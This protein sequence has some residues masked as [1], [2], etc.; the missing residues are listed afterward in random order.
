M[1]EPA[2]KHAVEGGA[3]FIHGN[4]KVTLELLKEAGLEKKELEG[5]MWQ[6]VN[7]R[8]KKENDFFEHAGMV[9]EK[10][11]ELK[12]DMS[13]AAFLSKY[14]TG[15]KYEALGNSLKSYIEGYYSG[16]VTKISARSFLEECLSEDEQQYRPAE[17][18][19]KMIE[20]VSDCCEKAGS[21]IQL[22]TVVKEIRWAKGQVEVIDETHHSYTAHK[23]IITVPLG[24]LTAEKDRRGAI[25]FLPALPAKTE[26]ARQMGFGAAIKVLLAFKENLVKD[27]QIQRQAGIDLNNLSMALSDM[28]IPTWWTQ[29]PNDSCLL[30]GWLSGPKAEEIKHKDD[31]TIMQTALE[32]LAGILNVGHD[33]LKERLQWWKVFNWAIDPFTKGSY[34]YSTLYTAKARKIL[35]EPV[36]D[37][38]FFAGEA[39]YEGPEMGTVEA[40]LTSGLDT[41]SKILATEL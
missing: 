1:H 2:I 39:L 23:A 13:I 21:I 19:G 30:T 8:W 37:T 41:A 6:F 29:L 16:E 38:L 34:S 27:E 25:D 24:V 5:E 20:Y 11:K 10:L 40:A 12:E 35:M 3:E 7:G 4:L 36:E 31:E 9:I 22:S 26:A 17:G 18:Y 14:F 15:H 32:S 28:P 33:S